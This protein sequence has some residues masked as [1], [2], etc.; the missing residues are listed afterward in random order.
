MRSAQRLEY[1]RIL[2]YLREAEGLPK[3]WATSPIR[4]AVRPI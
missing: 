3:T 1:G 4:L 2:T